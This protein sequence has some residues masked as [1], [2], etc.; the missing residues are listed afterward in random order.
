MKA[1]PGR[2]EFK[3]TAAQRAQVEAMASY[4]VP[5][6]DIGK[7]IGCSE[8]TLRKHFWREIET[9]AVEANTK[10]AKRLFQMATEG[11]GAWRQPPPAGAPIGAMTSRRRNPH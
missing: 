6:F 1:K 9:A 7:V 2:P 3:P 10:I 8:P 11:T 5:Q 4:G